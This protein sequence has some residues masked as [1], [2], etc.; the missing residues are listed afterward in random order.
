MTLLK[1]AKNLQSVKILLKKKRNN[2]AP[3]FSKMLHAGEASNQ[4]LERN[5]QSFILEKKID[6]ASVMH[7][8]D[9]LP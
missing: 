2:K 3:A 4:I 5:K 1:R 8:I 9:S 6:A 7:I